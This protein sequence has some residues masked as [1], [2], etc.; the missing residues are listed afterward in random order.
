MAGMR[1]LLLLA[2]ACQASS[3]ATP[4]AF[5]P[6]SIACAQGLG[7]TLAS[8]SRNPVSAMK[9]VAASFPSVALRMA[10][11]RSC[12]NKISMNEC[13]QA[14]VLRQASGEREG[15]A[16]FGRPGGARGLTLRRRQLLGAALGFALALPTSVLAAKRVV[17]PPP[18]PE[19][20]SISLDDFYKALKAQE[21]TS[22]EFDGPSFEVS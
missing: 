15:N 14:A 16:E 3:F 10:L 13:Q 9:S 20:P 8:F 11:S 12:R 6:P 7:H 22:V 19:G 4:A 18:K 1:C 21:V 17:V 2:A 5:T